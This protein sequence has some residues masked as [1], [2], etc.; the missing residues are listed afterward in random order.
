M[1]IS[2]ENA[3]ETYVW[4][5]PQ[6]QPQM[7]G[8]V[9]MIHLHFIQYAADPSIP[10][11]GRI[12]DVG[13]PDLSAAGRFIGLDFSSSPRLCFLWLPA[14]NLARPICVIPW[15]LF[16]SFA[17]QHRLREIGP[18]STPDS[19]VVFFCSWRNLQDPIANSHAINL[20][21]LHLGYIFGILLLFYIITIYFFFW[22]KKRYK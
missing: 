7:H 8:G 5:P 9:P 2:S 6:A 20:L 13:T 16:S 15:M 10:N 3:K 22:H 17:H 4:T 19:S 1:P 21:H 18:R 12:K 11:T 14:P